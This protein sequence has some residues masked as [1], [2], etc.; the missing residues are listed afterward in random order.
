MH[1]RIIFLVFFGLLPLTYNSI[2]TIFHS[3][4]NEFLSKNVIENVGSLPSDSLDPF[5]TSFL[6]VLSLVVLTLFS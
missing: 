3:N 4:R 1:F 6:R 5:E 2:L